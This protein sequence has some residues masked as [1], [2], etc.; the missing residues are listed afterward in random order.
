MSGIWCIFIA[1]WKLCGAAL[2]V[3]NPSA[4]AYGMRFVLGSPGFPL[5]FGGCGLTGENFGVLAHDMPQYAGKWRKFG[6]LLFFCDHF[7]I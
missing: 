4:L 3:K 5:I 1:K 6:V 7:V 2:A